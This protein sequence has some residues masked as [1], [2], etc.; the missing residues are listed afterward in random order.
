MGKYADRIKAAGQ[1]WK[2]VSEAC[3]EAGKTDQ[4]TYPEEYA[5]VE[6]AH[7]N[8]WRAALGMNPK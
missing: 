7:D 2:Q 3:E 6:R 4:K 5:K 8:V 1:E